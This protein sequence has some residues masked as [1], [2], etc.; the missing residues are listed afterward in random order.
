VDQAGVH[1]AQDAGFV[2]GFEPRREHVDAERPEPCRLRG[3]LRGNRD[4]QAIGCQ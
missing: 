3:L 4:F 1:G 2:F